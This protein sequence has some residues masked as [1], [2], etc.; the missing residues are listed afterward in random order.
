[1][2]CGIRL[3]EDDISGFDGD[4]VA[5]LSFLPAF[6][7]SDGEIYA[8]LWKGSLL[9]SEKQ[10][11]DFEDGVW[12]NV[13]FDDFAII[14]PVE[15]YYVGYR[16][17]SLSGV[18]P[19][20]WHDAGPNIPGKG[21][22]V[23]T[24][25]WIPIPAAFDFNLCIKGTIVSQSPT[26]SQNNTINANVNQLGNNYPNPF[27][28]TT[29]ISYNIAKEGKVDLAIYNLK[30]QLVKTLVS[31]EQTAGLH[32]V[33][34]NGEDNTGRKVSSGLYLYKLSTSDFNST[35]KMILLK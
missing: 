15:E 33:T 27:N 5:K 25:G 16:I 28:P 17:H 19:V 12:K 26:G 7:P 23:R 3:A 30:G 6:N 35:K 20:A 8:E 9:V 29:T 24:S 2:S 14:D 13:V 31:A 21:A 1:M 22:Y 4:A 18:I 10:I 11:T 34:W 32:D